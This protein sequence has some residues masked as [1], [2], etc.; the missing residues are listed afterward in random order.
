MHNL[1]KKKNKDITVKDVKKGDYFKIGKTVYIKGDYD[2]S[3][4][5]YEAIKTNDVWGNARMVKSDTKVRTDF[6][7]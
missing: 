4:K 2:R 7:Y 6:E 5:K 1:V 3:S